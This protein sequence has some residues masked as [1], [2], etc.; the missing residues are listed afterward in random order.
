MIIFTSKAE[1]IVPPLILSLWI[2][3]KSKNK[4]TT[5]ASLWQK[6]NKTGQSNT[7]LSIEIEKT[8]FQNAKVKKHLS[9]NAICSTPGGTLS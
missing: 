8:K 9:Q 4:N 1:N 2:C 6:E 7:D 5:S 3:K